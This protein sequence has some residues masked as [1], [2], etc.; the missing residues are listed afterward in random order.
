MPD[1]HNFKDE[2]LLYLNE[3]DKA[4]PNKYIDITGFIKSY[5]LTNLHIMAPA[6]NELF[7]PKDRSAALITSESDLGTNGFTQGYFNRHV[8][9]P[10]KA[11]ITALGKGYL[12]QKSTDLA[13]R[14]RLL[15][16]PESAVINDYSTHNHFHDKIEKAIVQTGD[17]NTASLKVEKGNKSTKGFW[18]KLDTTSK[19]II[20]IIA[21]CGFVGAVFKMKSCKEPTNISA[22][23]PKLPTSSTTK[24]V[25]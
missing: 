8:V 18:D 5:G 25:Q 21:L 10:I 3:E 12:S 6:I 16:T 17:G 23:P 20:A 4:N 14:Q 13:I 7:A 11:R 2:L 1:I 22:S 24:K 15:D 19:S 9:Q